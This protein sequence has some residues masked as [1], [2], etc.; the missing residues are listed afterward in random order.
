VSGQLHAPAVFNPGERA[1][2]THWIGGWVDPRAGQDDLEKKKLLTL[3]GLEL[4][5]LSLPAQA[6]RY[7]DYVTPALLMLLVSS[8]YLLIYTFILYICFYPIGDTGCGSWLRHFT[9]CRKVP[10]SIPDEVIVLGGTR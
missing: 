8:K 5:I 2:G 3:S 1:H 9:T 7:T 4:R 10:G 6:S